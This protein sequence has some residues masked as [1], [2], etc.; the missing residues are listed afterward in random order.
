MTYVETFNELDTEDIV[1]MEEEEKEMVVS[2]TKLFK[3]FNR[4]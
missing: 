2:V 1:G 4:D 3:K